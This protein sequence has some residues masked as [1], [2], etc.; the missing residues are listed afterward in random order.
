MPRRQK[1]YI[2]PGKT[3]VD[4][5]RFDMP[6]HSTDEKYAATVPKVDV[7]ISAIRKKIAAYIQHFDEVAQLGNREQ[8]IKDLADEC[9][10][11]KTMRLDLITK[12]TR[13]KPSEWT[14]QILTSGLASVM[15]RYGL[16]AAISEYYDADSEL[17]QSLYLRLIPGLCRI[18]GFP[19]PKDV[20]GLA[21][22]A[23]RINQ[24]VL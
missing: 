6:E 12:G 1:P 13:T 4:G 2:G 24:E 15:Q 3:L 23:K 11:A 14:V 18:A 8:F 10:W 17:K 5:A 7:D 9:A 16:R 22:R 21:L 20:K 19:L